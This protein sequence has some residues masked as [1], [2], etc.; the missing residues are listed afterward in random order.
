MEKH[1]SPDQAL[2]AWSTFGRHFP[3]DALGWAA[4]GNALANQS[5]WSGAAD[6]YGRALEIAPNHSRIAKTGAE[7][8][9]RAGLTQQEQ[10]ARQVVAQ[11]ATWPC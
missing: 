8:F 7:I 6:R 1:F 3:G 9:E 4:Q 11:A 2:I 10:C 5:D